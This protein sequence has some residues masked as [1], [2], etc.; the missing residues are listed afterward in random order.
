M[1]P[2]TFSSSLCYNTEH[3]TNLFSLHSKNKY[4]F[5]RF[6]RTVF[7]WNVVGDFPKIFHFGWRGGAVAAST[8]ERVLK[9]IYTYRWRQNGAVI[10]L[11]DVPRRHAIEMISRENFLSVSPARLCLPNCAKLFVKYKQNRTTLKQLS[12]SYSILFKDRYTESPPKRCMRSANSSGKKIKVS[13]E[14]GSS[15][16]IGILRF[17]ERRRAVACF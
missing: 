7:P 11:M 1:T 8:R 4:N 17:S 3:D 5:P 12:V 2:T 16:K 9:L 15:K 14:R 6:I 13:F 10:W